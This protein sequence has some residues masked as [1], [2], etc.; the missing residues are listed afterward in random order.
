MSPKWTIQNHV[1]NFHH[2]QMDCT[3]VLSD[4]TGARLGAL[5]YSE[6]EQQ[7]HIQMIETHE[8]HR[9]RGVA[10]RMIHELQTLYPDQEIDWGMTTPDGEAL[11]TALAYREVPTPEAASF[12]RRDRLKSRLEKME[13]EIARTQTAGADT[14]PLMTPYYC[15]LRL[16]ENLEDRLWGAART[17]QLVCVS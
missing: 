8:A 4:D 9:R 6:F 5:L 15:L 14:R 16:V 17:K 7:P 10:T 3:L 1:R 12:D 13:Q 11:R 2:G